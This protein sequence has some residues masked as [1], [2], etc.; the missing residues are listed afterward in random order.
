MIKELM[1]R[2]NG[3]D[4]SSSEEENASIKNC[5]FDGESGFVFLTWRTGPN[6]CAFETLTFPSSSAIRLIFTEVLSMR[7][8]S[9]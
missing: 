7:I 4:S 2:S 9:C 3:F 5:K 6:S 1:R 8:S